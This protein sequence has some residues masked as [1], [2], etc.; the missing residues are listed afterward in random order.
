[1]GT[2]VGR[3]IIIGTRKSRLALTQTQI[4]VDRLKQAFPEIKFEI[5]TM[6]TSGDQAEPA[7]ALRNMGKGVFVKEIENGLLRKRI[8]LAVHSLKDMPTELPSKLKLAGVLERENPGDVYVSRNPV[9][10]EKLSP[11]S[12]IGTSSLRRK[13]FLSAHYHNIQIEDLRGNLDTR[14]TKMAEAAN[15]LMGIVVA[16]A[17]IQRLYAGKIKHYVEPI[18][19]DKLPPAPGQGILSIETRQDDKMV[20]ELVA[21]IT[22]EPTFH[23]AKAERAIMARLQGGCNVPISAL[24]ELQGSVIK[25]TCWIA[26]LDGTRILKES[27]VGSID[28]PEQTAMALEVMLKSRGAGDLISEIRMQVPWARPETPA[29]GKSKSKPKRRAKVTRRAR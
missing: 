28:E 22:H 11:R 25:L 1:M 21:A 19:I 9:P 24:A 15:G 4:V 29:N 3:K 26:S 14:I 27:A 8:D 2:A 10:I 7:Q 23:C 13:A 16:A 6:T 18:P 5:K 12:K 20:D 17:G